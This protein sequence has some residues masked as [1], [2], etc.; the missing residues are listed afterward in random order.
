MLTTSPK[1]D[2]LH[3]SAISYHV[4]AVVFIVNTLLA[5]VP[6]AYP[7][8]ELPG[9]LEYGVG[10]T[11]FPANIFFWIG[12]YLELTDTLNK[13][14]PVCELTKDEVDYGS[15]GDASSVARGRRSVKKVTQIDVESCHQTH[16][17]STHDSSKCRHAW[18]PSFH[19]FGHHRTD[20]TVSACI[21][22]LVGATVYCMIGVADLPG[23]S[24]SLTPSQKVLLDA[25]MV[26]HMC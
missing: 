5:W 14:R 8:T 20:T 22:Q 3:W 4:G 21:I 25:H 12:A 7:R 16:E 10:L 6:Y 13:L 18:I 26:R 1:G 15:T 9:Q 23:V 19:L 11:T 24:S 17:C 2:R